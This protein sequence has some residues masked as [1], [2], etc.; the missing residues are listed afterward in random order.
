MR[1][2]EAYLLLCDTDK[3]MI[4]IDEALLNNQNNNVI[5]DNSLQISLLKTKEKIKKQIKLENLKQKQS[6]GKIF[7]NDDHIESIVTNSNI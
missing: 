5:I 2:S 6:F 4:I 3:A 1:Q 7:K